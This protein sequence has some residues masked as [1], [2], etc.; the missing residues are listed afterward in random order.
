M[1]R[2]PMSP[3]ARTVTTVLPLA[4]LHGLPFGVT[5]HDRGLLGYMENPN[6][7][8]ECIQLLQIQLQLRAGLHLSRVQI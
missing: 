2:L 1:A 8:S 6:S 7:N 4:I 3:H 5:R